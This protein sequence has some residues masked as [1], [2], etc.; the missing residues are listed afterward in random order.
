M[1]YYI[2]IS[3]LLF[4]LDYNYYLN[5]SIL[6]KELN[7]YIKNNDYIIKYYLI[8]KFSPTFINNL[9]II[10]NIYQYNYYDIFK[11]III[12]ERELEKIGNKKWNEKI[13]YKYWNIYYKINIII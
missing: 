4:Y 2:I 13:Y 6:S 1:N 5:L 8:K 9:Q 10:P 3:N 11:N 7:Y 12:F